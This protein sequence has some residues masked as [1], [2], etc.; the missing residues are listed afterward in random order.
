[1]SHFQIVYGMHREGL[2][3]LRYLGKW[4]KIIVEGDRFAV[5]MHEL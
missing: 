3:E 4:E 5:T 1:M 2:Y